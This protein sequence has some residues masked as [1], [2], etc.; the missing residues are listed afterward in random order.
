MLVVQQR[1]LLHGGKDNAAGFAGG[2]HLAEF[3]AAVGLF[4][5]AELLVQLAVQF[6]AVGDHDQRWVLHRRLL[7]QLP[8]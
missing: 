4:G 3:F 5:H 1:E 6:V 2:Q 8:A 7:Q